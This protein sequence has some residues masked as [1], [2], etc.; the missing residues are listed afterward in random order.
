MTDGDRFGLNREPGHAAMT[1]LGE[2]LIEEHRVDA[3]DHEVRVRMHVVV[4]RD[5][6]EAVLALGAEQDVVRD[7]VAERADG[8][9]AEIGEGAQRRRV[10][11]ADAEHLAEFVVRHRD[12]EHRPPRRRVFEAAQADVGVA[13]DDR[14]HDRREGDRDEFRRPSEPPR[15]QVR[16]LDVEADEAIGLPRIRFDERRAAFGIARPAKDFGRFCGAGTCFGDGCREALQAGRKNDRD[17]DR[18]DSSPE[19]LRYMKPVHRDRL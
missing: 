4:V 16:D 17:G 13:A 7:R 15:D 12:R 9:A 6:A 3:P 10:G 1:A 5:G 2:H 14:L 18:G 11:V 19:G 8:P